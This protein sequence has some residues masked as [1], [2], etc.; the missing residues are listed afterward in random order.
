EHGRSDFWVRTR[1]EFHSAINNLGA[2][3]ATAPYPPAIVDQDDLVLLLPFLNQPLSNLQ[4][5]GISAQGDSFFVSAVG[6]KQIG[7]FGIPTG[8]LMSFEADP[9]PI[10]FII[11][12]GSGDTNL[13]F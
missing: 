3:G 11:A 5:V 8:I 4:P 6:S 12:T 1:F 10:E 9:D 13:L 2:I 7:P